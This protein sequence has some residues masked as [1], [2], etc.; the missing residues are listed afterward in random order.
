MAAAKGDGNCKRRPP[1]AIRSTDLL[2]DCFICVSLARLVSG[3]RLT[4]RRTRA[5]NN[6][7]QTIQD[8][9]ADLPLKQPRS[10]F[11]HKSETWSSSTSHWILDPEKYR[12]FLAVPCCSWLIKKSTYLSTS[13]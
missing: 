5:G 12:E 6:S 11:P 13:L 8:S 3:I 2:A 1:A 10:T 9:S 7:L 4:V